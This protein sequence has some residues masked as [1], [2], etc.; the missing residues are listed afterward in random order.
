IGERYIAGAAL[1]NCRRQVRNSSVKSLRS[2]F[3]RHPL[4]LGDLIGRHLGGYLIAVFASQV[5]DFSVSNGR[6]VSS[7]LP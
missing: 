5:A 1:T 7:A 4:R 2:Q 3:A 6:L